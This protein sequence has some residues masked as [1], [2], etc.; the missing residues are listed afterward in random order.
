VKSHKWPDIRQNWI[1]LDTG[2]IPNYTAY[3]RHQCKVLRSSHF[4]SALILQP[5]TPA[6]QSASADVLNAIHN[7]IDN[8]YQSQKQSYFRNTNLFLRQTAKLTTSAHM[9]IGYICLT[10]NLCVCVHVL[11][12]ET[13]LVLFAECCS[14]AVLP[15]GCLTVVNAPLSL[16]LADDDED[17][18]TRQTY[19]HKRIFLVQFIQHVDSELLLSFNNLVTKAIS[20]TLS[21]NLSLNSMFRP[22]CIASRP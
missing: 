18:W 7:T 8:S 5:T 1:Q 2:C 11:V 12:Y 16:L 14:F 21:L 22:K 13:C 19:V 17:D 9:K 4:S 3:V 10:S 6:P 20:L 15:P